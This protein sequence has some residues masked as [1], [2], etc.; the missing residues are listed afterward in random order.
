[1]ASVIMYSGQHL[2]QPVR[3]PRMLLPENL[4]TSVQKGMQGYSQRGENNLEPSETHRA[5]KGVFY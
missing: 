5:K 2:Q 4:S 1:M 3:T